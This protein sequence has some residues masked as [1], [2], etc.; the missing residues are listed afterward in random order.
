MVFSIR[1][2]PQIKKPGVLM[3]DDDLTPQ[4]LSFVPIDCDFVFTIFVQI[5]YDEDVVVQINAAVFH[6]GADASQI[7]AVIKSPFRI[8]LLAE[9]LVR[10]F[11]MEN[12]DARKQLGILSDQFPVLAFE[13]SVGHIGV[14][15]KRIGSVIAECGLQANVIAKR[16]FRLVESDQMDDIGYDQAFSAT[17]VVEVFKSESIARIS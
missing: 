14:N 10:R 15:V 3:S 2:Q 1:I 16:E 6:H 11:Q 12:A 5:L 9:N 8:Q 17:D 4:I 7:S 13:L